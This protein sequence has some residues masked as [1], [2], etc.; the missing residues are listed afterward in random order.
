MASKKEIKQNFS[1]LLPLYLQLPSRLVWAP[2]P[3]TWAAH[4]LILEC[5]YNFLSLKPRQIFHVGV[6]NCCCY[7]AWSLQNTF[8]HTVCI[9]RLVLHHCLVLLNA[10]AQSYQAWPRFSRVSGKAGSCSSLNCCSVLSRL[11]LPSKTNQRPPLRLPAAVTIASS[12][13]KWAA[14]SFDRGTGHLKELCLCFNLHNMNGYW[15]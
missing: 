7:S 13:C 8:P 15:I 5:P 10:I 1:P 2:L 12:P 6:S 3:H 11:F 4:P 9:S 14:L